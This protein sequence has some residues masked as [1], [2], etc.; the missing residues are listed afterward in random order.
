L[1]ET[2]TCQ[3]GV[4]K[5]DGRQPTAVTNA[6]AVL[7]VVAAAEPGITAREIHEQLAMS[8]ATAYRIL[9]HLVEEGYL[10]HGPELR[11]FA[12]GNRMLVFSRGAA[13]HQRRPTPLTR[14]RLDNAAS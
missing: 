12:L 8:R 13:R 4:V 1:D 9:R 6:L 10:V 5:F 11:G 2:S 7:E 14:I 3:R